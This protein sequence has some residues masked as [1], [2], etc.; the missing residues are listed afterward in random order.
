MQRGSETNG[1]DGFTSSQQGR[2]YTYRGRQYN[3]ELFVVARNQMN[4]LTIITQ[5]TGKLAF[6][7]RPA[8]DGGAE[9]RTVDPC[10]VTVRRMAEPMRFRCL[11]APS[12]RTRLLHYP[13]A[14]SNPPV[15][16]FLSFRRHTRDCTQLRPK[17]STSNGYMSHGQNFFFC[18]THGQ[19][20]IS[21][22]QKKK[23]PEPNTLLKET[24]IFVFTKKRSTQNLLVFLSLRT[25]S[26]QQTI[27][28]QNVQSNFCIKS[29]KKEQAHKKV[30]FFLF[31]HHQ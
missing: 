2:G 5:L 8:D 25:I 3:A 7:Q 29:T 10:S 27:R 15:S 1:N 22:H 4:I 31:Y 24:A 19:N 26:A 18:E 14:L 16:S 21:H 28:V 11:P 13:P 9:T 23:G 17:Q 20:F 6:G 12:S 30:Q